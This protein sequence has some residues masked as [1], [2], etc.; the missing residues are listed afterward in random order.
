MNSIPNLI[1]IR[2]RA[3]VPFSWEISWRRIFRKPSLWNCLNKSVVSLNKNPFTGENSIP[4]SSEK[5]SKTVFIVVSKFTIKRSPSR[6]PKL[7][8][9]SWNTVIFQGQHFRI[10]EGGGVFLK[11]KWA[12]HMEYIEHY[13]DNGQNMETYLW[14]LVVLVKFKQGISRMNIT[15]KNCFCIFKSEKKVSLP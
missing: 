14:L 8:A 15:G 1:L 4:P 11:N 9:W 10:K 13:E 5:R 6:V 12:N 7:S 2:T 3:S